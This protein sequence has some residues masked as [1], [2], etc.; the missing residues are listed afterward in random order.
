MIYFVTENDNDKLKAFF[1]KARIYRENHKA[2]KKK[3]YLSN[4]KAN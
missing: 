3:N 4:R 1:R 2:F